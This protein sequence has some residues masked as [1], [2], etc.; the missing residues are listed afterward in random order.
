MTRKT[1]RQLKN[2]LE[3]IDQD[4]DGDERGIVILVENDD[5]E[6]EDTL[7]GETFD[8]PAD[9]NAGLVIDYTVSGE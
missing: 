6:C 2:E 3:G 1:K 5:G 4:D 8:D 7:T 9:V